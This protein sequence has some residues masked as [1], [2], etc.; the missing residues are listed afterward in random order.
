MLEGLVSACSNLAPGCTCIGINILS[1]VTEWCTSIFS[2]CK[3]RKIIPGESITQIKVAAVEEPQIDPVSIPSA[4]RNLAGGQLAFVE[5]NRSCTPEQEV[6]IKGRVFTALYEGIKKTDRDI[7]V[8]FLKYLKEKVVSAYRNTST[9]TEAERRNLS[10]RIFNEA[11]DELEEVAFNFLVTEPLTI[12]LSSLRAEVA[13]YRN[14]RCCGTRDPL[15]KYL[16]LK[17]KVE[18]YI[19][20]VAFTLETRASSGRKAL[21]QI[22]FA[23]LA[24]YLE[25]TVDDKRGFRQ[26]LSAFLLYAKKTK[27]WF[28]ANEIESALATLTPTQDAHLRSISLNQLIAN[29]E[30]TDVYFKALRKKVSECWNRNIIIL[31]TTILGAVSAVGIGLYA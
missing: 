27:W 18:D 4:W 28:L 26:S 16:V 29:N 12:K 24:V 30:I 3:R 2:A 8:A 19:V 5:R 6:T 25:G 17:D 15:S 7:Q 21:Q 11:V 13:K 9:P 14:C 23:L 10:A 1:T 20:Q 31:V 22:C